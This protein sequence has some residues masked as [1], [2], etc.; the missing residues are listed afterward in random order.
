MMWPASSRYFATC[1]L[2]WKLH[3]GGVATTSRPFTGGLF[4]IL[5]SSSWSDPHEQNSNAWELAFNPVPFMPRI[6]ICVG[7]FTLRV[8]SG[9]DKDL[10]RSSHVETFEIIYYME[11]P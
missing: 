6:Y 4:L 3:E 5:L 8:A 7:V 9:G 11:L 10:F 2:D 1:G